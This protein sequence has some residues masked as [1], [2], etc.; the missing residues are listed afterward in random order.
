MSKSIPDDSELGGKNYIS[1]D[2][3]FEKASDEY[4]EDFLERFWEKVT[5]SGEDGCW[6]WTA[7]TTR[8]YGRIGFKGKILRPHRVA[9]YLDKSTN[10]DSYQANHTCHNTKCVNPEH[11]Y[12]GTQAENHQDTIENGSHASGESHGNAK[13]SDEEVRHIRKI[14]N[15]TGKSQKEIADMFDITQRHVSRLV[16]GEW[17]VEAGGPIQD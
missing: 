9:K 14:Y 7:C 8:G 6:N 10:I 4:V 5:K 12:L 1:I 15:N 2:E 3:L 16:R 13:L 11:I 17:R